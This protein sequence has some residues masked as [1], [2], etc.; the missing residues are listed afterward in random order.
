MLVHSSSLH[1]FIELN[2]FW[3]GVNPSEVRGKRIGCFM[4]S[5]LGEN[6][7]LFLES[8]LSG[9]GVTGH[10]RAMMPNRVSYWLDLKGPSV[11]YDSNW[12]SG[13]EVLRLAYEAIKTGQCES[14]LVGSANLVLNAE[15]QWLYHDMG[16]LSPDG[17]TRAFDIDGKCHNDLESQGNI[18]IKLKAM[19]EAMVLWYYTSNVP[20]RLGVLTQVLSTLLP[21]STGTV[22]EPF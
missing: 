4:S 7:S 13:I 15:F 11:H 8:V 20:A 10:S 18:R 17:L 3:L 21:A 2:T 6:D 14:V 9:F 16:L 22:K 19:E 12:I 5:S 1:K